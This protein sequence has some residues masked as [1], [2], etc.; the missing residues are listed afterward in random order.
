MNQNKKKNKYCYFGIYEPMEIARNQ[1]F[2]LGLKNN[3]FDY[4]KCVDSS[5][6]F[7][8]FFNLIKKHW[9]IRKE[10]DFIVVGYLSN[11]V[12]PLARLI[13]RKKVIFNALNAMYEG[14]IL[15]RERYKKFSIGAIYIWLRDFLAFHSADLVL[16][17][18][19]SQKKFISK[20]FKVRKTKLAVLMTGAND[21]IFHPESDIQK[22]D[23]FSVVFRGWFLPATGVEYV[24]EAAR[25]LK[26]DGIKFLIIGRGMLLKKI[27]DMIKEYNLD[28]IE[29]ITEFLPDDV[30]REKMLSCNVILG[31]FA[32][33]PRMHRTI[34]NKTFEAFALRMPYITMDSTSNRELLVNKENCL[35]V[36]PANAEDL[37]KKILELK[38]DSKLQEKIAENGYKLY[39]EKLNPKAIGIKFLDIFKHS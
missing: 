15:D 10:Y 21:E 36:E 35:F 7:L 14:E 33:H 8:K 29:L 11:I 26:K 3:G 16:V 1:I 39:K 12:V 17:E 38:E 22:V 23:K 6:S 30:L 24:I 27:E 28:N 32:N 31:Q 4:I 37:A 34:Q 5:K 18:S 13:S 19:E 2:T 25:I 9:K 20:T